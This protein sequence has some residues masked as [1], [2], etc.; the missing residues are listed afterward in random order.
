MLPIRLSEE[1]VEALFARTLATDGYE[2]KVDLVGQTVSDDSDLRIPFEVDPFRRKCL[3]EGLDDI[4]LTLQ[5]ADRI[6]A[7]ETARRAFR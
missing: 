4:S 5:H 2:L 7:F 6:E 1:Q 3:L